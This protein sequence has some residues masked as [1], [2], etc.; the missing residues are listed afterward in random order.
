MTYC[1]PADVGVSDNWQDHLNRDSAE[2]GTDYK[3]AYGTDLRA[4]YGGTVIGVDHSP[5]GPEGRRLTFLLDN[6]E[7]I[8]WI[9]LAAI[10]VTLGGRVEWG[11]TGIALS[12]ASGWGRDWWYGAHLH[13]TRRIRRGL[14]YRQTA[15]FEDLAVAPRPASAPT[16]ASIPEA[17]PASIPSEEDDMT[18]ILSSPLG[19]SVHMG[20]LIVSFG[21]PDDVRAF[22]V[23]AGQPMRVIGMSAA[24]HADLIAKSNRRDVQRSNLPVIVREIGG[25]DIW[26]MADGRISKLGDVK[27]VQSLIDNGALSVTWPRGEIDNLIAQQSA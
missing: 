8:D 23:E 12:G 4:P 1:T 14:T 27:T 22:Q 24:T 21:S 17:E 15:N 6:G 10:F 19:Q 18:E 20:G 16:P 11:M 7:V 5:L 25:L 9:H 26:Q 3:T 13:V 2:P